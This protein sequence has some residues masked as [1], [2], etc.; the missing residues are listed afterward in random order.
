[1][2]I[3]NN[4]LCTKAKIDKRFTRMNLNDFELVSS[5]FIFIIIVFDDGNSNEFLYWG[6]DVNDKIYLK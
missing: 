2:V 3:L 5:T 6:E 1:V 4:F